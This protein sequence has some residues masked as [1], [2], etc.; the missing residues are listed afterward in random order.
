MTRCRE[1][2]VA[3]MGVIVSLGFPVTACTA[4]NDLWGQIVLL[5]YKSH[6]LIKR[7]P[8][9]RMSS[10]QL[11]LYSQMSHRRLHA[12]SKLPAILFRFLTLSLKICNAPCKQ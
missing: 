10:C 5:W 1:R 8:G 3:E 2:D 12:P 7:C 6:R 4:Y 11:D 9:K